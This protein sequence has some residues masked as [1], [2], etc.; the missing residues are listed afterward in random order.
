MLV[1]VGDGRERSMLEAEADALGI[2]A[3]VRFTGFCANPFPLISHAQMLVLSSR[4]EGFG[5][6]L[7]EAMT[8]GTPVISTDCP[9]R[10][11]DLL[12]HGAVGLL[13]PI[14]DVGAMA[15]A[16]GSLLTDLELR[17]TLTR[18]ALSRVEAFAPP[19]ANRRML[20]LARSIRAEGSKQSSD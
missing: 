4:Y 3:E 10:P 19:A 16:M 18:N 13:V 6:V 17:G 11:R 1:L 2:A 8:L 14:G 12:M 20:A 5:M 9:T 7:A 15:H